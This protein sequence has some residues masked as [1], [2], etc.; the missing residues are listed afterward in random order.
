[1]NNL[2]LKIILHGSLSYK[3]GHEIPKFKL[4]GG[5]NILFIEKKNRLLSFKNMSDI[6]NALRD[7]EALSN[8]NILNR[9][10]LVKFNNLNDNGKYVCFKMK[11][12]KGGE[13]VYNMN[14]YWSYL[15][16]HPRESNSLGIYNVNAEVKSNG[17]VINDTKSK[18]KSDISLNVLIN[19]LNKLVADQEPYDGKLNFRLQTLVDMIRKKSNKVITLILFNCF[20]IICPDKYYYTTKMLTDYISTLYTGN[21]STKTGIITGL[22]TDDV[23]TGQLDMKTE[24][25]I[26]QFPTVDQLKGIKIAMFDCFEFEGE[27]YPLV[28]D[29]YMTILESSINSK[30]ILGCGTISKNHLPEILDVFGNN[31]GIEYRKKYS[32]FLFIQNI[33]TPRKF[34]RMGVCNKIVTSLLTFSD[35]NKRPGV[36]LNVRY[37]NI[38]AIKCY[39]KLKFRLLS[40]KLRINRNDGVNYIMIRFLNGEIKKL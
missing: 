39:E 29:D 40:T 4:P 27:K 28:N 20:E 37:N 35:L 19:N 25:D 32:N 15:S 33:C 1:M 22:P 7:T 13:D 31:F 26:M 30:I 17:R 23:G 21:T 12:F 10:S 5:I 36:I 11:H 16:E 8:D 14:L 24:E 2:T 3:G 34:S 6:F 38:P 9:L 18:D